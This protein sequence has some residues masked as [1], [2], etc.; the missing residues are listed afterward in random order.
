MIIILILEQ[1]ARGR[2][3]CR[4][5][6]CKIFAGQGS[7]E[8]KGLGA[9]G[10]LKAGLSIK[11]PAA[12]SLARRTSASGRGDKR[13]LHAIELANH[14]HHKE[15]ESARTLDA[16]QASGLHFALTVVLSESE[17]HSLTKSD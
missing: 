1:N 13:A 7:F 14:L 8:R 15:E 9:A 16:R 6:S 17:P 10:S 4:Q 11:R 12:C 5:A 3:P 2:D